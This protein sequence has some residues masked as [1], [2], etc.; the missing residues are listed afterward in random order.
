[1]TQYIV[2]AAR[3]PDLTGVTTQEEKV[4]VFKRVLENLKTIVEDFAD[5]HRGKVTILE[6]IW[7]TPALRVEMPPELLAE[8]QK[9]PGIGRI[10]SPAF[11]PRDAVKPPRPGFRP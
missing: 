1:M 10:T 11:S 3:P 8:F 7:V 6:G 9:A 4:R 5:E 2:E